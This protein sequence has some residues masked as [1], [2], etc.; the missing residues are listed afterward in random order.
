MRR[1]RRREGGDLGRRGGR[2]DEQS[3]VGR[4][5]ITLKKNSENPQFQGKKEK[6]TNS[7]HP[8]HIVYIPAH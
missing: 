4:A 6:S 8:A 3:D 5:E 7:A 2:R 1:G